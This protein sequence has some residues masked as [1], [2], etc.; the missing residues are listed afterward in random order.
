[1]AS[2]IFTQTINAYHSLK[3]VW[4]SVADPNTNTSLV[5]MSLYYVL[6]SGASINIGSRSDAYMTY[7]GVN[8]GFTAN[9]LNFSGVGE[10]LLGTTTRTINHNNDGTKTLSVSATHPL[11]ATLSGVY[12]T[13]VTVS[14][15]A[16]LDTIP[17]AS[18]PTLSQSTQDMAQAITIFTNR[19]SS[20]FTH[21]LEYTF[22]SQ[23]DVI[24]TGVTDSHV[25]A[26]PMALANSVPNGLSGSGIITC[27][28]YNAGVL[29]GTATVPFTAT[30][31]ASIVPSISSVSLT[32]AVAGLAAQFLAYVRNKSRLNVS[33]GASGAYSSSIS[34]YKTTILGVVYNSQTFTSEILGSAGTVNVA[35]EVTDSRGRKATSTVPVTVVDYTNPVIASMSAYRVNGSGVASDD[36]TSIAVQMNFSIAS[37]GNRNAKS[38][39]LEYKPTS[40][41]VW[42][43]LAS[44][45]VY[46][47]NSTHTNLTGLF[48]TNNSYDIRLTISDYF[49][50]AT[51]TVSIST[52]F[53]LINF[54][55]SGR[56]LAIGKV[57]EGNVFEVAIP[58]EF[59]DLTT[60]NGKIV[61]TG[62]PS[63]FH[64]ER[65]SYSGGKVFSLTPIKA[66]TQPR[67]FRFYIMANPNLGGYSEYRAFVCGFI[68][69]SINWSGTQIVYQVQSIIEQNFSG[70]GGLGL[71]PLIYWNSSLSTHTLDGND[72]IMIE[73][74][75]F[76][77]D[78]S[79]YWYC[80]FY[81]V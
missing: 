76:I 7:E 29:I 40:T 8:V 14:G 74:Q 24:A 31:P 59:S 15:S 81:E 67:A 45:S 21:T 60:I 72:N 48:N 77:S 17:R 70:A 69:I 65:T 20:A 28:T 3:L 54:N 56:G 38:W 71:T 37:V 78:P 68:F 1:M 55:P 33:I 12:Y 47:Y 62:V 80:S 49:T 6:G 39:L 4:S 32:E 79:S 13:S 61:T 5:T 10:R 16:V 53:T 52:A 57:S 9:A 25:W 36:G 66:N 50:S 30:V 64:S 27:K 46:A 34:A 35:V 23:A 75:G 43:T 26:L 42:S 41:S 63:N 22:G 44:G 11:R 2:G 19:A 51:T 18:T 73:V 58:T